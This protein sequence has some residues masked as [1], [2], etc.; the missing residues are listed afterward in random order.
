MVRRTQGGESCRTCWS[1]G[2]SRSGDDPSF[3]LPSPRQWIVMPRLAI[4]LVMREY[5]PY[6]HIQSI[7]LRHGRLSV[8]IVLIECIP[9]GLC[10]WHRI[11]VPL[12]SRNTHRLETE[13]KHCP[14]CC[15]VPFEHRRG[16]AFCRLYLPQVGRPG[17]SQGRMACQPRPLAHDR[18]LGRLGCH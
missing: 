12:F 11:P 17:N 13:P 10:S 1:F 14:L 15:V 7:Y 18:D 16:R 6:P 9:I 2:A 8:L 5:E 3:S 4:D